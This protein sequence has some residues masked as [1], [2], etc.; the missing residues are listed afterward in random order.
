MCTVASVVENSPFPLTG[1][2]YVLLKS[3]VP[4]SKKCMELVLVL[5][6]VGLYWRT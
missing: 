1:K 6:D 3:A 2:T 5:T 4:T